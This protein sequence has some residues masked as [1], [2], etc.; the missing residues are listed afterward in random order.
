VSGEPILEVRG[1]RKRYG[2]VEALRG[3]DFTLHAGEIVGLVGDNGAG[4]STLVKVISGAVA[5]DDGEIRVDGK[6]FEFDHPLQARRIG[7][8]TMYQ[9]LSLVPTLSI[10]ENAYL[11]REEFAGGR[12]GRSFRWMAK[13]RMRRN[14]EQG[15]KE[16]G[17]TLPAS[18]TKVTAL[19]GGQ[20]QAVA[21]ARAVL[22]GSH[23]VLLD[24]PTAALGVRQTE[25]VLSF[26]ERL[27]EQR[28]GVVFISHDVP[29]LL[30]VADRLAVLRLGSKVFDG[31]TG[32]VNATSLVAMMT[33]AMPPAAA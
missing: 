26:I 12:V 32:D 18:N 23:I 19:S 3:V 27:R 25:I 11:G 15:F 8:E 13:K 4:K 29:Q 28:V 14:V 33:G 5:P 2:S 10:A 1:V 30:R 22:W 21:I 17:L 7:I 24:E 6:Q 31:P 16:L 20:R 9:D